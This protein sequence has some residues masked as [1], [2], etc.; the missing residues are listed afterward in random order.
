MK[1][2]F[3]FVGPTK[4]GTTWIDSYLRERGDVSLPAYTKETFFF[5]KAYNKGMSWY[6]NQFTSDPAKTVCVEVAPSLFHKPEAAARVRAE[7]P[8]VK[9]I[10]TVRDPIDRAVSHYFHY[11]KAGEPNRTMQAM[12][13]ARPDIVLPGLYFK[14]TEM[15]EEKFG[16]GAVQF[17]FY[18]DLSSRPDAF[19]QQVCDILGL[20]Y[21]PPSADLKQNAVNEAGVPRNAF[22]AKI[23]RRSS[24]A[25][26]E[27][28]ANWLVN[29]LKSEKLKSTVF[30]GGGDLGEE[31]RSIRAQSVA[32]AD[33]FRDDLDKFEQRIGRSIR[34][35]KPASMMDTR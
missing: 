32:L 3:L 25:L 30:A 1:P 26:R 27:S 7:L 34:S 2:D 18:D 6:S 29:A 28:G 14:N 15:W 24:D 19:C 35:T 31:R 33:I 13:E 22:L 20:P 21:L 12:I 23:V 5:D 9:I 16:P 4:S 17:L 11:R 10:C 8:G